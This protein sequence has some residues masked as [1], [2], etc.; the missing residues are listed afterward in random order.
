MKNTKIQKNDKI[1][2]TVGDFTATGIVET[3]NDW[4]DENRSDWYIE[5]R[6]AD[7]NKI[8]YVKEQL[9]HAVIEKL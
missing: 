7:D 6:D 9:D 8:R 4:G 5:M 2:V 3:A 1:K